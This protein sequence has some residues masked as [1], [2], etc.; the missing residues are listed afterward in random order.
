MP[1]LTHKV[2]TKD[3]ECTVHLTLDLNI[4]LDKGAV[5]LAPKQEEETEII[6]PTFTSDKKINFGKKE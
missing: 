1:S 4:N 6:V 5:S 2:T 3:G